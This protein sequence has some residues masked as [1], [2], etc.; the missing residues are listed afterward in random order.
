MQCAWCG[1]AKNTISEVEDFQLIFKPSK[2]MCTFWKQQKI[3]CFFLPKFFMHQMLCFKLFMLSTMFRI[4]CYD[5]HFF[6]SWKSWLLTCAWITI[7]VK[8]PLFVAFSLY[9]SN[10]CWYSQKPPIY[11]QDRWTV[12]LWLHLH[13]WLGFTGQ[14]RPK[15]LVSDI[16]AEL[17]SVDEWELP[18]LKDI[19]KHF[20]EKSLY[21][22]GLCSQLSLTPSSSLLLSTEK[23]GEKKGRRLRAMLF[24]KARI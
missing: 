1:E 9:I 19:G 14:F 17:S 3:I 16:K 7:L 11:I 15:K 6:Y 4:Y 5:L 2:M 23:H 24:H 8:E 18:I 21:A 12:C 20:L 10:W 22:F 13:R